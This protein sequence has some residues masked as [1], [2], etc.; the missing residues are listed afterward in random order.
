VKQGSGIFFAN[1]VLAQTHG[2]FGVG[3]SC[4]FVARQ[5]VQAVDDR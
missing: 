5:V 4:G 1:E 3:I 2:T